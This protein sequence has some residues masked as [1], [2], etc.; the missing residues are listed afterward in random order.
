MRHI[1]VLHKASRQQTANM[2]CAKHGGSRIGNTL[3]RKYTGTSGFYAWVNVHPDSIRDI[4]AF[5][6]ELEL[7]DKVL[8]FHCTTM[9]SPEPVPLGKINENK[10]CPDAKFLQ[11]V[12]VRDI[13]YWEGHK[14]D[15]VL[16]M[17]LDPTNMQHLHDKWKA[18]GAQPTF[19][20]YEPHITLKTPVA[21]TPGLMRWIKRKNAELSDQGLHI[22]VLNEQIEDIS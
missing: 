12:S 17:R 5:L 21:K 7:S 11:S 16:V 4:I 6:P 8:D 20:P 2:V 13:T 9:Y 1:P 19:S 14:K 22:T 18:L 15:G 3:I 10:R